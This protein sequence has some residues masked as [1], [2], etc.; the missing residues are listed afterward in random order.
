MEPS[1]AVRSDATLGT[2]CTGNGV[3]GTEG[4]GGGENSIKPDNIKITQIEMKT[5][6][7]VC[8]SKSVQCMFALR[9]VINNYSC[10]YITQLKHKS[11]TY[12][13]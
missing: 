5:L 13:I 2:S 3:E 6:Q 12:G 8:C 1:R 11:T 7:I 4:G 10:I 9:N